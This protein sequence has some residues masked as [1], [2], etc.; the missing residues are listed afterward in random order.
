MGVGEGLAGTT[1]EYQ[2]Q[3][4]QAAIPMAN[5][6]TAKVMSSPFTLFFI[7]PSPSWLCPPYTGK[8]GT[9]VTAR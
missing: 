9:N 4:A 3:A 2:L 6:K 8:A 1:E 7:R 5:T